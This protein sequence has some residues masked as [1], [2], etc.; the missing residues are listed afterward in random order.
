MVTKIFWYLNFIESYTSMTETMIRRNLR[1]SMCTVN[2]AIQL[3]TIT[4]YRSHF[5]AELDRNT[6]NDSSI[7]YLSLHVV[8][9]VPTV[10][11]SRGDADGAV[12]GRTIRALALCRQRTLGQSGSY[13]S[14]WH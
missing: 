5:N 1:I 6:T 4:I 2:L 7:E 3:T 11:V 9:T 12:T 14:V 13:N 10:A 8:D